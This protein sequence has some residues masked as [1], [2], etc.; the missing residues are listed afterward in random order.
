MQRGQGLSEG[1]SQAT[2][3]LWNQISRLQRQQQDQQSQWTQLEKNYLDRLAEA[4]M[5]A[6][7]A[8]ESER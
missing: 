1:V 3:P 5:R 2:Q 4:E 7:Q 8:A 6:G